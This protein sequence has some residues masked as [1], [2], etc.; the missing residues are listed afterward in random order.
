MAELYAK[1]YVLE[2]SIR[3]VINRVMMKAYGAGWWATHAPS[4]VRKTVQGRKDRE[5]KVPWHGKRGVHE[6]YY[7]DFSDLGN[8]VQMHWA[9]FKGILH[10]QN[11]VSRLEEL[12]PGRNTI[13]HHNPVSENER[14]RF[15]VFFADWTALVTASRDAIP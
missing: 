9:Q 11:W 13:A 14:K 10:K 2:N 3:S 15:E 8:I 12:E 7:S 1:L 6:L 4:E 5:D